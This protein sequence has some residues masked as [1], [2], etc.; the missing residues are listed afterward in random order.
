MTTL[1]PLRLIALCA[2]LAL[3]AAHAKVLDAAAG[4]F[5]VEH[6]VDLPVERHLAWNAAVLEIGDWWHADHTISGDSS[7]LYINPVPLGCFCERLGDNA[8]LV[9]MTVTF[10]NPAVI[11]RLTGGLGPLGLMGINGN[12]T[13]EFNDHA[14]QAGHSTVVLRYAVGGYRPGGLDAVAAP[15][16][17]VLGEQMARLAAHVANDGA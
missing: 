12:L 16:D 6:S 1:R 14:E 8:G 13:L 17:A 15:V 10:V 5:T 11:L 7:N 2:V 4:G 9:H 3:P